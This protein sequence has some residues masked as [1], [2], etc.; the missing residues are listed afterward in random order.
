MA[1][2]EWLKAAILGV[3][4]GITEWLPI[5]STGHMVL[6]DQWM[7]LKGPSEFVDLFMVVVQLG[8]ILAVLVLYFHKLNPWAPAKTQKEKQQTWSLWSKVVVA[9]IPTG[10]AGV[11]F[12]EQIN[13]LF[14]APIPIA[15]A[16]IVY[17]IAFI[18]IE[19][20][21]KKNRICTLA[22]L[23]YKTAVWIGVFQILALIPGTSRSG[24]TILGA[25]L[26]GC[27]RPVAAEFSFFL[28][29][30]VTDQICKFIDRGIFDDAVDRDGCGLCGI[31]ICHSVP[32]A[33]YSKAYI[34]A[35]WCV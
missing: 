4:Q 6:A 32:D 30:P 14:Y 15:I 33:V 26:L 27:A 9:V 2:I 18:V 5:S 20:R 7:Q 13:D 12:E 1:W 11:L 35:V 24:S 29:I 21:K 25:V 28:A 34:Q 23:D 8:S 3:I 19:N 17:G 22:Q 10:I 31:A 16:L